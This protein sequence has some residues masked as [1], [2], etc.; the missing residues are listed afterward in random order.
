M[1]GIVLFITLGC[2]LPAWAEVKFVSASGFIVENSYEVD[3][4]PQQVWE[5][6]VNHVGDWWPSD[7]T[8]FGDAHNLILEARPGGCFCEIDGDRQVEHMRISH[9]DPGRLLRMLGGLGP[10][11]GMGM[12]GALDW[13]ISSTGQRSKVTLS[14]RVSGVNPDGFSQ[15]APIVDQVQNQ[16]LKGLIDYL[17]R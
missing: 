2:S 15:L 9:V 10:L 1:R 7:H 8:W 5:G 14:Y 11:Q 17:S 12:H 6:L 16:Q 4:T 13:Q 3:S